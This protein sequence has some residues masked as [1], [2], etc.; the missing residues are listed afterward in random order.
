MRAFVNWVLWMVLTAIGGWASQ[1]VPVADYMTVLFQTM[2]VGLIVG[3]VGGLFGMGPASGTMSV[4]TWLVV[5][6]MSGGGLAA[7]ALRAM[8]VN[9]F[10]IPFATFALLTVQ[11]QALR[12]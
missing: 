2:V 3:I 5:W 7:L 11:N 12:K 1:Y 6:A 10:A 4:F 8:A 9:M